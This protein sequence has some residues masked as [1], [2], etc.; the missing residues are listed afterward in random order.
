MDYH[1]LLKGMNQFSAQ[2]QGESKDKRILYI[3]YSK[4]YVH[5]QKIAGGP[6]SRTSC[7]NSNG[8]LKAVSNKADGIAS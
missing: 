3:N 2:F 4:I 5:I 1:T 7:P 8:L 6:L